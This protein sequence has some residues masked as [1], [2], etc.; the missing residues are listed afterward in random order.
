MINARSETVAE[1]PSLRQAFQAR[2]C[3]ITA[4]G[5]FEWKRSGGEK[6]P[7]YIHRSDGHIISLAGL[8]QTWRA[9]DGEPLETC[10]ILTTAANS[11]VQTIH[12][13]M[14]V[15]LHQDEWEHWLSRDQDD[16]GQL[17]RFFQP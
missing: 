16:L 2:R 1:K 7:H 12:D 11:L 6:I 8:W 17:A 3:L 5:F 15:I 13:R 4:N 14:P 10:T 9:L